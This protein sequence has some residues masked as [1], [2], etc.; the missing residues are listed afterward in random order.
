MEFQGFILVSIEKL[1][2]S[3][4]KNSWFNRNCCRSKKAIEGL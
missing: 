4:R 1:G 3:S 2:S